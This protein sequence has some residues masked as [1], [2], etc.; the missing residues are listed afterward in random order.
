M[1]LSSLILTTVV[2]LTSSALSMLV[3]I[4]VKKRFYSLSKYEDGMVMLESLLSTLKIEP[5][6]LQVTDVGLR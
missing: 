4:A 2:A 1:T 3:T 6:S 5:G